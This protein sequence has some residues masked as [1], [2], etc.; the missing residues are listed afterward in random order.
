M[1][2]LTRAVL[3]GRY[4]GKLET[5]LTHSWSVESGRVLC[6]GVSEESLTESP[7]ADAVPTCPN[8]RRIDL[9]FVQG[10]R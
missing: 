2:T 3:A 8:C 7:D 1:T 6:G 4:K 9:R 5:T 10:G